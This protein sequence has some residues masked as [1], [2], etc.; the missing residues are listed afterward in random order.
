MDGSSYLTERL[1][2]SN[3][4]SP[5]DSAMMENTDT[6]KM[7]HAFLLLRWHFDSSHDITKNC[8]CER[9]HER[10]CVCACVKA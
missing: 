9:V 3:K 5:E 1:K 6:S 8:V 10:E 2:G 4:P 7:I